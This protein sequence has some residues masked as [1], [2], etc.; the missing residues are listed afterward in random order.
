M[1]T[2]EFI[3]NATPEKLIPLSAEITNDYLQ[4]LKFIERLIE[5]GNINAHV[6][7]LDGFYGNTKWQTL[8]IEWEAM[9]L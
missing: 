7:Q 6:N 9:K 3:E 1:I 4:A 8:L 5:A 2:R